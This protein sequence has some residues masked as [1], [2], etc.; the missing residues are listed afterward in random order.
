M[1][2]SYKHSYGGI[3]KNGKTTLTD[4]STDLRC[5]RRSMPVS[6]ENSFAESSSAAKD[7]SLTAQFAAFRWPCSSY[8]LRRPT[9]MKWS[10]KRSQN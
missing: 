7:N 2:I 3:S 8:A 1:L 9:K 6:C 4:Y 10:Q 5:G